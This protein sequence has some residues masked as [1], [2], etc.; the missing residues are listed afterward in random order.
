LARLNAVDA[1][2]IDDQ[3]INDIYPGDRRE[4]VKD[5]VNWQIL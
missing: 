1:K 5:G 4:L 2:T 3:A